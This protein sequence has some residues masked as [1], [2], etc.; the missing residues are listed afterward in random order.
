LRAWRIVGSQQSGRVYLVTEHWGGSAGDES[1]V[2]AW[3]SRV[4]VKQRDVPAKLAAQS[5][6]AER[7]AFIWATPSSDV[8]VQVQLEPG[9]DHPFPVTPPRLLPGLT[10]VWVG[11]WATFQGVLAWFPDRGW[12]R[13][14]W[15]W[16]S[17]GPVSSRTKATD[18][19]R[20]QFARSRS[21]QL[22]AC[23]SERVPWWPSPYFGLAQ[24]SS[25]ARVLKSRPLGATA[26]RSASGSGPPR[27]RVTL[28]RSRACLGSLTPWSRVDCFL[29][30]RAVGLNHVPPRHH[31]PFQDG[32]AGAPL[33]RL[34][35]I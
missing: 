12:W 35:C 23:L 10:D 21:R 4:L 33:Q 18:P 6:V 32:S 26:S 31:L 30:T 13:T 28:W 2:G 19:G 22:G 14:P 17:E 34:S 24:R 3:V 27:G 9:D 20:C 5:D 25:A 29:Y 1:T 15:R 11:G 7:H 8:G 16:P